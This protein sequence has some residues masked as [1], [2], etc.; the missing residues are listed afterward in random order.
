MPL[1]SRLGRLHA[2]Q[3][4]ST[5]ASAPHLYF[6]CPLAFTSPFSSKGRHHGSKRRAS[7]NWLLFQ[8]EVE[9]VFFSALAQAASSH[10]RP[11]IRTR[12]TRLQT[13]RQFPHNA[14]FS[15]FRPA[16]KKGGI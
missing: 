14:N 10:K 4:P 8:N 13:S 3:I 15:T 6:L 7:P 2:C 5:I 1:Q 16:G 12:I 9:R 11:T